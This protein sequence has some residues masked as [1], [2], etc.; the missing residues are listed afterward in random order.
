M[1][2]AVEYLKIKRR[3]TQCCKA[4]SCSEC[5]FE[6][7]NNKRHIYCASFEQDYPREAVSV[8][9]KWDREH[10]P[11][12]YM[13]VFLEKFPN[14][15]LEDDGSGLYPTA[16]IVDVYCEDDKSVECM[17]LGY[18]CYDCWNQEVKEC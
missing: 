5:P 18:T 9:E 8:V 6:S 13:N 7:H 11:K 17:R 12:T 3:M 14:A 15:R 4:S 1:M 2:N 10:P 16:C